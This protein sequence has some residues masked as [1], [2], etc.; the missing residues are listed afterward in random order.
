MACLLGA[1]GSAWAGARKLVAENNA[2]RQV[3]AAGTDPRAEECAF[4][5]RTSESLDSAVQVL[6]A[7]YSDLAAAHRDEGAAA[8]DR[9]FRAVTSAWLDHYAATA[10]DIAA[11]ADAALQEIRAGALP[12]RQAIPELLGR[13]GN[14]PFDTVD[15]KLRLL[16]HTVRDTVIQAAA[17]PTQRTGAELRAL[18][19]LGRRQRT[20]LDRVLQEMDRLENRTADPDLLHGL[21][22]VDHL[23]VQMRRDGDAMQVLAGDHLRRTGD[24]ADVVT[25]LRQAIQE[26]ADY[27]RVRI[28]TAA[29][30]AVAAAVRSSLI[31]VVAALVENGTRFSRETVEVDSELGSEGLVITVTDTGLH[32]SP[33]DL[34]A[35]N[36]LLSDPTDT[37]VRDRLLEGRIGLLAVS[38]LARQHNLACALHPGGTRGTRATVVVPARWLV[39]AGPT[40]LPPQAV[41]PPVL[42]RPDSPRPEHGRATSVPGAGHDGPHRPPL[43]QRSRTTPQ[44][45]TTSSPGPGRTPGAPAP[46]S[47]VVGAFLQGRRLAAADRSDDVRSDP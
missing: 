36:G 7:A 46:A 6:R 5:R 27:E 21:L 18:G 47:G 17:L 15:R 26:I 22:R 38:R 13:P 12:P 4:W 39:Q 29:P 33:D 1:A 2:A 30:V 20:H 37:M 43:P 8:A 40:I 3:Q 31:H 28:R 10:E 41:A 44:V 25:I 19:G 24:A 32:M 11:A 45:A 14:S 16:S 34:R 9:Q 42:P 23:L 35:N